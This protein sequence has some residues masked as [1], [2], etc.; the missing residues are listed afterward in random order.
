M[1]LRGVPH[2]AQQAMSEIVHNPW[3]RTTVRCL[4]SSRADE[5]PVSM[6]LDNTEVAISSILVSWREPDYVYFRVR[7]KDG[8]AHEIRHHEY[9]DFWEMR[10][11]RKVSRNP[12]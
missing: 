6:L 3:I 8:R 5:R 10:Q 11:G 2:S 9:E 12:G 4:A 1:I 7:T